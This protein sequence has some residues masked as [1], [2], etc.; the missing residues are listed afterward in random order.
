MIEQ[1]SAPSILELQQALNQLKVRD[2]NG[3]NLEENGAESPETEAAIQTL[4]LIMELYTDG[5]PGPVTWSAINWLREQLNWIRHK[6]QPEEHPI[7]RPNHAGGPLVRYVQYLLGSDI[8]GVYS[9]K[10]ASAVEKFQR[11]N[12]LNADGIIGS[13]T[14]KELLV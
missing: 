9:S 4:Q 2:N 10:T 1:A 6:Q 12:G 8:D 3:K 7:L 14:W 13:Q 11:E 5:S